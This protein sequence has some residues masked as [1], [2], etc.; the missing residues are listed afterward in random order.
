[1]II[2]MLVNAFGTANESGNASKEYVKDEII[3]CKSQWQIDLANS[4]ISSGFA[5]ETKMNAPTETK[6]AKKKVAKKKTTK[7]K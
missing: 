5:E 2:K 1:M 6:K 4:F 7:K 3:E